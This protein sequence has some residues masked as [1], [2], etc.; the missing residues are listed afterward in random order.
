MISAVL[1]TRSYQQEMDLEV[2][3]YSLIEYGRNAPP[4]YP[5]EFQEAADGGLNTTQD[6]KYNTAPALYE[7]LCDVMVWHN[8]AIALC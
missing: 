4:L 7:H 2:W 8:L 3:A 5:D 6:I 1:G